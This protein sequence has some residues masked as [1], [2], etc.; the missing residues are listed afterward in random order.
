M[1]ILDQYMGCF[2]DGT[3]YDPTGRLSGAPKP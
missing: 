3:Y 2:R 1:A